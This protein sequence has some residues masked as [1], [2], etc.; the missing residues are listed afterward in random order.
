MVN[1]RVA[2]YSEE[3]NNTTWMLASLWG[4]A[5]SEATALLAW[6]R[7]DEDDRNQ[8]LKSDDNLGKQ[9][10]PPLFLPLCG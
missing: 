6:P 2:F 3:P 5:F 9:Q 7:G 1:F 10:L 4:R 8:V